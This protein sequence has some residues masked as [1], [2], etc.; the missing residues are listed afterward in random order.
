MKANHPARILLALLL[1]ILLLPL[2]QSAAAVCMTSQ[3]ESASIE[4]YNVTWFL[5]SERA[6][7]CTAFDL[8]MDVFMNYNTS[9]KQWNVWGRVNGLPKKIGTISLP[10]GNGYTSATIQLRTAVSF[11]AIAITP[12]VT[13]NFSWTMTVYADNFVCDNGSPRSS[14]SSNSSNRPSYV[15]YGIVPSYWGDEVTIT[16]N[17]L[18]YRTYP[19]L[20][21]SE[22][23]HCKGFSVELDVEM[24][25]NTTCKE[26]TVWGLKGEDFTKLGTLYLPAGDGVG[27]VDLTFRSPRTFEGIAITPLNAG[28]FSY[29]YSLTVYDVIY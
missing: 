10:D 4:S 15:S 1:C 28:N 21:D 18:T 14:G 9:C 27:S 26:W 5:L 12:T 3:T 2:T 23:Y 7:K 22:L 19:L 13:G 20:F 25:Y 11:D 17:S 6:N 8:E 24:N 29:T 16:H